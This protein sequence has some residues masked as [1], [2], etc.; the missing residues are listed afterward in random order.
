MGQTIR[1]NGSSLTFAV[2]YHERTMRHSCEFK[3]KHKMRRGNKNSAFE[4]K[5]C[6]M[7]LHSSLNNIITSFLLTMAN[8]K[9]FKK[10]PSTADK[11]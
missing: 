5:R 4:K 9:K 3:T 11:G 1:L 10:G 8:E 6:V 7:L 2:G